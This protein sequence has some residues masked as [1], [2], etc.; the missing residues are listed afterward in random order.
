MQGVAWLRTSTVG[1]EET[2]FGK[3]GK[4]YLTI[5]DRLVPS[6][7]LI[8]A[9]IADSGRS[10]RVRKELLDLGPT[11][12]SGGGLLGANYRTLVLGASMLAGSPIWYFLYEIVLLNL[13]LAH[14]IRRSRRAL[15]TIRAGL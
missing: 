14:G 2:P 1:I 4:A 10:D 3:I 13:V 9:A 11:A 7:P 8:D 15:T 5:A 6:E 12:L